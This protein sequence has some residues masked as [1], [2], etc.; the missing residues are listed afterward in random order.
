MSPARRNVPGMPARRSALAAHADAT[1]RALERDA[2]GMLRPF[3]RNPAAYANLVISLDDQDATLERFSDAIRASVAPDEWRVLA[4]LSDTAHGTPGEDFIQLARWARHRIVYAADPDTTAAV[5]ATDWTDTPIPG[6]ALARLPHPDPLIV[7]PEPID[8]PSTDGYIERYAAFG[9]FGVREP[10]RRASTHHPDATHLTLHFFGRPCDP[11]T[12]QPIAVP[13]ETADGSIRA[14]RPIV[15]MRV[16][17]PLAD[18]TMAEREALAAADM[19][20]AGPAAAYGFA[21][22]DAAADAIAGLTRV[23]LALLVYLVSDGADTRPAGPPRG[24]APKGQDGRP[25][26]VLELGFRVGAA[27]RASPAPRRA[28]EPGRAQPGRTVA[29]HIRR[30]HWH[31]Y[32][33][34][35][36]RRERVVRWL[37]P[38]PI[39]AFGPASGTQVHLAR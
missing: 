35:P 22:P 21:G 10:R 3:L 26:R 39:N 8:L 37:P 14:V 17:T 7:L 28:G 25:T 9:V 29:P 36:G 31:V 2:A 1:A 24:R 4:A 16:V 27:L 11:G 18:A 13:T 33:V 23:G 34:G 15:G 12:G 32:R 19:L 20:A 5:T 30:A 6:E 38:I